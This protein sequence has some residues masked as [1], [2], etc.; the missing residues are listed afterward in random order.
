M[1][2]VEDH[3]S[4]VIGV[5]SDAPQECIGKV[6]TMQYNAVY[7]YADV[8]HDNYKK[9]TLPPDAPANPENK[10][11]VIVPVQTNQIKISTWRLGD[12]SNGKNNHDDD[13]NNHNNA[14]AYFATP[15]RIN[16]ANKQKRKKW[17]TP[18]NMI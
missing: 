13:N 5:D 8:N 3:F 14:N 6:Y 18:I 1:T 2:W 4:A 7:L 9:Y 15:K 17:K 12:N 16:K 11:K 10:D